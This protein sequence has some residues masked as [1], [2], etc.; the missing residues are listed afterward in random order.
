[1]QQEELHREARPLLS[2]R[3]SESDDFLKVERRGMEPIP[4]QEQHGSPREIALVWAGAMAN[5]V[6]LL[7]G[8]LVIAAPLTL[9]LSRGQLGLGDSA[10]AILLGAALAA[11]L[12]GF[13]SSTGARTG[14]PQMIFS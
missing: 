11:I 4:P 5:Y 13:T 14:T 12:H 8:A 1:M 6:S 2:V 7:T 10:L 9:G 3:G